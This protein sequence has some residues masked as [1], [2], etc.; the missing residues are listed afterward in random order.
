MQ[1]TDRTQMRAESVTFNLVVDV[2]V[3]AIRNELFL[4]MS[5]AA[6]GQNK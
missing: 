3:K 1:N 2:C 6:R 5:V 4:M